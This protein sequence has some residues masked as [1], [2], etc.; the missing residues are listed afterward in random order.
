MPFIAH[1]MWLKAIND[2]WLLEATKTVMDDGEVG[3]VSLSG[4]H[5]R[6]WGRTWE[7]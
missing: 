6:K 4:V 7:M 3:G 5:V 2:N 1:Q